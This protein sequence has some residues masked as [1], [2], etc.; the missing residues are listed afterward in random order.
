MRISDWSSDVCSSDLAQ[1]D[2]WRK[3]A[4]R[5]IEELEDD[6]LSPFVRSTFEPILQN[7]AALLDSGA[8]YAC[9]EGDNALPLPLPGTELR[10]TAGFAFLTRERRATQ[11]LADLLAFRD[12]LA[13]RDGHIA[14]PP[15]RKS[16]V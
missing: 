14:I 1:V 10:I 13:T 15:D 4:M 8:H 3:L 6:A 16:V 9:D 11:L 2:V 12:L 5:H 7:A